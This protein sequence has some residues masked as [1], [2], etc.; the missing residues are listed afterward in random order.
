MSNDSIEDKLVLARR[1][2]LSDPEQRR[3]EMALNTSD[4][5]R[6]LFEAGLAFDGM[7]TANA[8]D[9]ELL[10][11]VAARTSAKN[12]SFVIRPVSKR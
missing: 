1:G 4:G 6:A 5:A 2:A 8:S 3:L 7:D 12:S 9:H 10:A 11:R